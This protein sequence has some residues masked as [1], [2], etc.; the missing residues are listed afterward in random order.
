MNI[1]DI[2]FW[3]AKVFPA[4]GVEKPGGRGKKVGKTCCAGWEPKKGV[5]PAGSGTYNGAVSNRIRA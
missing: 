4:P 2:E 1:F 3:A 5:R